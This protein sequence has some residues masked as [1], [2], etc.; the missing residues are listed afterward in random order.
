MQMAG[1]AQGPD[2]SSARG[3]S[4]NRL[5]VRST[6]SAPAAPKQG[7]ISARSCG[8][9]PNRRLKL[10]APVPDGSRERFMCGEVEFPL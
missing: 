2:R 6:W 9:Q 7:R 5:I 1:V 8:A 4:I 10:A 3:G